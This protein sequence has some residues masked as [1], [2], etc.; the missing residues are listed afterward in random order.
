M[1]Q[2]VAVAFIA[3]VSTLLGVMLGAVMTTRREARNAERKRD[4]DTAD[5]RREER[6]YVYVRFL[7]A[8]DQAMQ[9]AWETGRKRTAVHNT[10]EAQE[11]WH[12]WTSV[13]HELERVLTEVRLAAP[14]T[15]YLL[16]NRSAMET[17]VFGA[18]AINAGSRDEKNERMLPAHRQAAYDRI[19]EKL[20]EEMQ[21]DLA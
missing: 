6:R 5:K 21:S 14:V 9:Q 10:A 8:A 13:R 4:W 17:F 2:A 20:V 1:E 12:E 7:G 3:P 18:E 15:V 11:H 19:V 16:S